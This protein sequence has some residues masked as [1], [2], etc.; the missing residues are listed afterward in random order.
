MHLTLNPGSDDLG[1]GG[2][3][4]VGTMSTSST[5]FWRQDVNWFVQQQNWTRSFHQVDQNWTQELSS[6][7]SSDSITAAAPDGESEA[8]S[9]IDPNAFNAQ[10]ES[11]WTIA[12]QSSESSNS[13]SAST[14]EKKGGSLVDRIA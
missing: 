12:L 14:T 9:I 7:V 1:T 4:K 8:A 5:S 10:A 3:P 11:G 13:N 2:S 6:G